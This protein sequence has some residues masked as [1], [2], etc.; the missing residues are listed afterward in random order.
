MSTRPKFTEAFLIADSVFKYNRPCLT[1]G[2]P[3]PTPDTELRTFVVIAVGKSTIHWI[4]YDDY[5]HYVG[6]AKSMSASWGYSYASMAYDADSE[7][8]RIAIALKTAETINEFKAL[9]AVAA[10]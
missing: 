9:R 8:T 3:T 10:P 7:N 1:G 5:M 6:M 4:V 2:F